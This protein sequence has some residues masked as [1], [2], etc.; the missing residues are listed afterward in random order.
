[1]LQEMLCKQDQLALKTEQ[2]GTISNSSTSHFTKWSFLSDLKYF[3][4]MTE[5]FFYDSTLNTML[6][7]ELMLRHKYPRA[8]FT[9]ASKPLHFS[10]HFNSVGRMSTFGWPPHRQMHLPWMSGPQQAGHL[11]PL[12]AWGHLWQEEHL[13]A[14]QP[15]VAT[16]LVQ[17]SAAVMYLLA[18][19][20][21]DLI[22]KV[23][24]KAGHP[25]QS[26]QGLATLKQTLK[27]LLSKS[28]KVNTISNFTE[29]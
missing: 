20:P 6:S 13:P 17:T 22:L 29:S 10:E 16:G 21:D 3:A 7:T 24:K 27:I 25:E 14:G 11:E 12:T 4:G 15:A 28:W 23:G 26:L 19:R 2:L 1:M 18:S 8:C 5:H 9:T